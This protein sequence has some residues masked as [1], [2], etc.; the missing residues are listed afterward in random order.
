VFDIARAATDA[1]RVVSITAFGTR[2]KRKK[3]AQSARVLSITDFIPLAT[4]V[5]ILLSKDRPD[6]A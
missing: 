1:A 6:T 2:I 5:T 3:P 4:K